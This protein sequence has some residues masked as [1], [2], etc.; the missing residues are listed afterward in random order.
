MEISPVPKKVIEVRKWAK[1]VPRKRK[2]LRIISG[3]SDDDEQ[4]VLYDSLDEGDEGRE[5]DSCVGCGENYFETRH[6]VY[7]LL[8]LSTREL[9]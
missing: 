1:Q 6:S 3:N 8:T 2:S 5:E 7:H 9:H 4:P